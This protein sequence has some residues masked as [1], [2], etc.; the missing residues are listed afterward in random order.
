M[1]AGK[2]KLGQIGYGYWGQ[3]L[4]GYF[5]S[6]PGFEITKVATR[7]HQDILADKG[8]TAVI[9]A[10]PVAT[11]FEIAK[12]VLASGKHLFCEKAF[13]ATA[14][15]AAELKADAEARDLKIL[16]DFTFTFSR[17]VRNLVTAAKSGQLGDLS[18]ASFEMSQCG[19]FTQE[20]VYFTLG[21]HMLSVLNM[22]SPLRE[23]SFI[24]NDLIIRERI[25]EAGRI[26]FAH[27]VSPFHG[28]I[29]LSLNNTEKTRKITLYGNRE[30]VA[31]DMFA[32]PG[33]TDNLALAVN[34]FYRLIAKGGPSNIDSALAVARTL[35][36]LS[37]LLV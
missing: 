2:I 26:S 28:I 16:V 35:D 21:S 23:F 32:A 37:P 18:S 13:T 27:N 10:T 8:I 3:K 14:A 4:Q 36:S 12:E 1:T 31:Y 9:V 25:P 7:N 22:I 29:N 30:T 19:R 17:G 33:E 20:G 6:H 34:D 15:E 11:H 5:S 24:R